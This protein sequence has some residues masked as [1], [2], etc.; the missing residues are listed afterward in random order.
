MALAAAVALAV[1][2][3]MSSLK[4]LPGVREAG[5]A[6]AGV[7]AA[8]GP[9]AIALNPAAN[10]GYDGF[11]A[12]VS[13]ARWILDTH[14]QSLFLARGFPALCV[15]V[16]FASYSAGKFEYRTRPTEEPIGVFS[17]YDFTAY[18]NLARPIG[19]MV[20]SAYPW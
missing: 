12:T 1:P 14:H 7:A 4:I 6:G 15:G 10:A 3:G 17:P 8:F 5:M 11:V 9:Q 20:A 2:M 16:G 18:F 13:Y 19:N